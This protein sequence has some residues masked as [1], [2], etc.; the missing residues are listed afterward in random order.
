MRFHSPSTAAGDCRRDASHA[1]NVCPSRRGSRGSIRPSPSPPPPPP[2]RPAAP[3]PPSPPAR[4]RPPPPPHAPRPPPPPRQDPPVD[5]GH[6]GHARSRPRVQ[7]W[8]DLQPA[9]E[10]LPGPIHLEP[11]QPR[12]G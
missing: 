5:A 2:T 8:Q 12:H 6:G 7:Q 11:D 9:T 1:P 10:P 4:R 3:P